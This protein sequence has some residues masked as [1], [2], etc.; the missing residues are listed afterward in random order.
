MINYLPQKIYIVSSNS[1]IMYLCD[2][3]NVKANGKQVG[4][5]AVLLQRDPDI[6]PWCRTWDITHCER[7]VWVLPVG[8]EVPASSCSTSLKPH[9]LKGTRLPLS[10][11]RRGQWRGWQFK[12]TRDGTSGLRSTFNQ[13]HD[14]KN[15]SIIV[16]TIRVNCHGTSWLTKMLQ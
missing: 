16:R 9:A 2:L 10:F 1:V 14:E 15:K 12:V 11:C 13:Q 5:G 7:E 8:Q 3:I 6:H 4:V